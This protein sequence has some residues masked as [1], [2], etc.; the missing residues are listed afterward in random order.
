MPVLLYGSE[1]MVWWKEEKSSMRV[2]QMD[3]L[4]DLLGIRRMD[5]VWNA[6]MRKHSIF[7]KHN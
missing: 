6:R 7:A 5:K 4:K 2:V 1:T 3:N